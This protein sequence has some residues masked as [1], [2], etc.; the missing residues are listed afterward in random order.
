VARK[1]PAVVQLASHGYGPRRF[2]ML[3][4]IT[5]ADL[6]SAADIVYHNLAPTPQLRWPLLCHQLGADVWVKHE[7]HTTVGAFKVRGGLVYFDGLRRR[8]PDCRGV[9]SATRGN[10][11]QS[12]GYAAR[13]HGL[14]AVIFVPHGN[15]REKNDAMRALCVELVEFGDDFQAARERAARVAAEEALHFVPAF[16]V[17]LV[18]G[19]A[20]YWLEF[21]RSIRDIDV[22]F[23]PIGQGSGITACVAA[24][25]ALG[26][27]R[28]AIV[29]VVSAHAPCYALSLAEGHG[30]DA[31]AT[32][33]LADGL[34]CRVPDPDALAVIR[35]N[36]DDVLQ[37]TDAEVA[38]AMRVMFASTHN[39]AEGAGAAA[40]AGAMQVRSSLAGRRVGLVLS[41]GNVDSDVFG[42]VLLGEMPGG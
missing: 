30:V 25:A 24:R 12:V 22:V 39:A 19:V 36:V 42:K 3:P 33:V 34:A 1:S 20:S 2:V 8:D 23:V 7:N 4:P 9:I 13:L 37:V 6:S 16:H 28:P 27:A 18:R 21:L 41:G 15:S 11:G 38:E 40:L 14:R 10:H 29:G 31:P 35:S 32:T 26:L 5:L 17:D